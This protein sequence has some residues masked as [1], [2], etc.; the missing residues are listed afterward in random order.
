[1]G[2]AECA[3]R[4][5]VAAKCAVSV[6][7][8]PQRSLRFLSRE[9]GRRSDETF[10][11]GDPLSDD[12]A[13]L[14][15]DP[16]RLGVIVGPHHAEAIID[17]LYGAVVFDGDANAADLTDHV[18]KRFPARDIQS[19]AVIMRAV[20]A[21]DKSQAF[22]TDIFPFPGMVKGH[23]IGVA[24]CEPANGTRADAAEHGAATPGTF[25]KFV[26]AEAVP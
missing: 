7:Q 2:V 20:N 26:D 14:P 6:Y 11:L 21:G 8:A 3:K 17:E 19:A 16:V 9:E 4:S 5:E 25:E 23:R 12:L 10:H 13:A 1:M 24:G 22:Y 15:R 18:L